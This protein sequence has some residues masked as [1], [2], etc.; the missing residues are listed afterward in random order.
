MLH[1]LL[2]GQVYERGR[3]SDS[4]ALTEMIR[5]L[6]HPL[7]HDREKRFPHDHVPNRHTES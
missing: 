6:K 5:L 3:G 1:S 2:K 7:N 4:P